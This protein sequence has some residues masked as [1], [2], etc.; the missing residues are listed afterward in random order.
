VVFNT[1]RN[2]FAVNFDLFGWIFGSLAFAA[3]TLFRR[4]WTRADAL[5]WSMILA[6]VGGHCFYWFSGGA[7]FGARY[8]YQAF[9]PLLLLSARGIEELQ[10]RSRRVAAFVLATV[11]ASLLTVIPWR[12]LGMYY[13]YRDLRA[14]IR[15]VAQ[16]RRFGQAL[17]FVRA[18][19]DKDYL[20]A[21]LQNPPTLDSPGPIYARDLGPASRARLARRFPERS[22]WILGVS[23]TLGPYRVL[24][25]PLPSS[26]AG[27]DLP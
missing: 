5:L 11:A 19:D 26:R 3:L 8:W 17:V 27:A 24:A 4:P 15:Q 21:F 6:T 25:G 23:E 2:L 16:E 7:D 20:S 9:V 10:S 22:V 18:V 13:K 12:S 14:D 1:T